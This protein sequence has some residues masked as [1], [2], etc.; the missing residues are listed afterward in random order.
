MNLPKILLVTEA[1]INMIH[2]TGVQLA[3]TFATYERS[4]LLH[5][6]PEGWGGSPFESASVKFRQHGLFAKLIFRAQNILCRT[7]LGSALSTAR[8]DISSVEESVKRFNPDLILG[9]VYTN[10]GL[11]LM[12]NVLELTRG[13]R[14]I[15]WFLDL[16]L[17]PDR[18]GRLPDL[19]KILP[20][21][22]EIWVL[23][24]IMMEWL[25]ASIGH[26]P[27]RLQMRVRP[28]WCTSVSE[29]YRRVHKPFSTDFRC[30]ILGNIWDPRM[31]TVVRQLWRECQSKL[32]GL[33][34][35]QWVCH[36]AGV[37]RVLSQGVELGSEIEWTGGVSEDSVH[38]I[39]I[40][41]DLAIIPV[42]TDARDDYARFSVPSKMGDLAAV[43][44]PVVIFAGS[45]TATARYVAEYPVGELLTELGR[46]LW[47]TRLCEII[48]N[49]AERSK[50]SV[51]ARSYAERH[52]GQNKVRGE[53]LD[54]LRG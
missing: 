25:K 42:G 1:P 35:V 30:I 17:M 19:Q 40:N 37:Q 3:R 5:V 34:P 29:R 51:L 52:L 15:L 31:V 16:Q 39:A 11:R 32:S 53:I 50:L 24:P 8:F 45:R 7:F 28:H 41:A 6:T 13:K 10:S 4:R 22:S 26:W 38:D 43:G 47:P 33:A 9:V 36:E 44:V 2:G 18:G 21:L 12:E 49:A 14:A 23:S 20:D 46:E 27:E 54:A 48:T